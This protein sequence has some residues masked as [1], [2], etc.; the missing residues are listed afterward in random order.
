MSLRIGPAW[1]QPLAS[2]LQEL[3]VL[4]F[5]QRRWHET[6]LVVCAPLHCFTALRSLSLQA[7]A[8]HWAEDA[9]LPSSLTRLVLG[10]GRD[11][12]WEQAGFVVPGLPLMVSGATN[13]Q[14]PTGK[15]RRWSTTR[16]TGSRSASTQCSWLPSPTCATSACVGSATR[17]APCTC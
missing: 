12:S 16:P 1:L 11:P 8:L 14:S 6:A 15:I 7:H 17:A 5:E 4:A 10:S 3:E 2:R 9:L 13:S